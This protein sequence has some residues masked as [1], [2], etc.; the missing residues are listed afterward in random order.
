MGAAT[1]HADGAYVPTWQ[2]RLGPFGYLFVDLDER[3]E[4]ALRAMSDNDLAAVEDA[5]LQVNRTNCWCYV[6]DAAPFVKRAAAKERGRRLAS[7]MGE[8]SDANCESG[9]SRG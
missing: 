2:D 3:I 8:P 5:S 4:A 6:Y 1:P 7:F 9:E